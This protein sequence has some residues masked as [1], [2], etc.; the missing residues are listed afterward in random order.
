MKWR[1]RTRGIVLS[2]LALL[3]T[4]AAVH[5][6]R[7][8]LVAPT[9][10]PTTVASTAPATTL[11]SATGPTTI[12]FAGKH[13]EFYLSYPGSW[14]SRPN[15]DYVLQLVPA[16]VGATT[17]PASTE[18]ATIFFD[19]PDLP[20]HLPMMIT[21]DRIQNGY[22]DDLRK[23]HAGLKVEESAARSVPGAQARLVRSTWQ[24]RG[25]TYTDE[26]LMLIHASSVYILNS[27]A[28]ADHQ[29]ATHAVFEQIA[30]T[31]RWGS[32]E[33]R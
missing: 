10:T 29:A 3:V 21:L 26:A 15:P 5:G 4:A 20:P 12:P 28:D 25:I 1:G 2:A 8:A 7:A 14:V 30:P 16:A 6:R 13:N 31:I 32:S 22:I 18:A 17:A 33:R 11:S 27:D 24:A 19:V 23:S 9:S